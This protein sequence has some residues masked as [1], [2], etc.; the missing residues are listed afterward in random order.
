[1]YILQA[2]NR[3]KIFNDVVFYGKPIMSETV[4]GLARLI[5]DSEFNPEYFREI[6]VIT[7]EEITP[8]VR[9]KETIV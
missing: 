6:R 4:S 1:M 2:A 9:F 5:I 8:V 3:D 7:R